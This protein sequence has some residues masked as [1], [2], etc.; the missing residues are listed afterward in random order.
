[1]IFKFVV[2][3]EGGGRV[4]IR[5]AKQSVAADRARNRTVFRTVRAL[6]SRGHENPPDSA[7]SAHPRSEC[8]LL[9]RGPA[10]RAARRGRCQNPQTV[11]GARVKAGCCVHASCYSDVLQARVALRPGRVCPERDGCQH[12]GSPAN[13]RRLMSESSLQQAAAGT[14]PRRRP[15]SPVLQ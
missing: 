13:V 4:R 14:A 7:R 12:K 10:A 1:M 3:E 11:R 9:D 6:L 2:G 5:V 15:A 8:L